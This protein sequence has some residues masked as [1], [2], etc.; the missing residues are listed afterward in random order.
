MSSKKMMLA[1]LALSF[2]GA[3]CLIVPGPRE[4]SLVM[5]PLLPPIV[6]LGPEPYYEHGGYHY[7]YRDGGWSYSHSRSG[8]WVALPRDHYPKE[9]RSRNGEVYRDGGRKPGHPER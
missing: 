8:P 3:G 7:Y 4:G 6:T 2:I 1:A 5:V 9:V